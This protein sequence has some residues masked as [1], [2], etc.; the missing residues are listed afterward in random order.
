MLDTAHVFLK[1][2]IALIDENIRIW[3]VQFGARV[4]ALEAQRDRL[5]IAPAGVRAREAT[6]SASPTPTAGDSTASKPAPMAFTL[7]A[8]PLTCRCT[9]SWAAW[10]RSWRP[11]ET[12]PG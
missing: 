9:P 5:D 1:K 12:K 8:N 3:T 4:G 2:D 10:T 11:C 6:G 7:A